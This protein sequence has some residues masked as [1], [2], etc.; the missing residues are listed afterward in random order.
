LFVVCALVAA[1]FAGAIDSENVRQ[2]RGAV[3]STYGAGLGYGAGYVSPLAYSASPVTYST[4]HGNGY[5]AYP[6]AASAYSAYPTAYS[7]GLYGGVYG[8]YPAFRSYY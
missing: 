4:Y 3:I 2:T 5:N 7:S 8:G 6:Y 1:A